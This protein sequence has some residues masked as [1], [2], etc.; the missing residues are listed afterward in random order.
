MAVRIAF[1]LSLFNDI[2]SC[3][4]QPT[5]SRNAVMIDLVVPCGALWCLAYSKGHCG[6]IS[7][8]K[9]FLIS[10][11][12]PTSLF[13]K[14]ML[15][16]WSC[17]LSLQSLQEFGCEHLT[18]S[19]VQHWIAFFPATFILH[20]KEVHPFSDVLTQDWNFSLICSAVCWLPSNSCDFFAKVL[21]HQVSKIPW[22]LFIISSVG[23]KHIDNLLDSLSE[24]LDGSNAT[25]RYSDGVHITGLPS[26][27]DIW[28]CLL[29]LVVVKIGPRVSFEIFGSVDMLLFV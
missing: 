21:M 25:S 9:A 10:M 7:S 16:K 5:N 26:S 22:K 28:I 19:G 8:I 13:I 24:K 6:S 11:I 4:V 3:Y 23:A 18:L 15:F 17:G 29:P 1:F 27:F 12:N 20:L 2:S 14:Y